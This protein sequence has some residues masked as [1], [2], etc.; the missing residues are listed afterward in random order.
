MVD[1]SAVFI[2]A[3]ATFVLLLIAIGAYYYRRARKSATRDWESLLERLTPLDRSSIAE[4]AL[5][6][7]DES[8]QQRKDF[9][10]A[11]LEPSEIWK[12]LGGMEGVQAIEGN[13]TVL[14][15]LAFYL[16]QWYPEALV[17]AEQ[18][19]LS[20]RE[21][22]WHVSQLKGA[23]KTGKLE[24]AIPMYAQR[25]AAVYFLMTRRVLDLYEVGSPLMLAP[26]QKAL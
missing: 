25:A 21:I 10:S 13:C 11:C 5:D 18:L 12:L 16:Q 20:A 14:I 1:R 22:E 17:V 4:V 19:R 3:V 23:T 24:I 8:G 2:G 9:E 6:I 15:D 26:L 7:I